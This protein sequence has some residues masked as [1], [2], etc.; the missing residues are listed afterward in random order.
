MYGPCPSIE[1]ERSGL[2][3]HSLPATAAVREACCLPATD[4]CGECVPEEMTVREAATGCRSFI[5]RLQHLEFPTEY[6]DY[7]RATQQQGSPAAPPTAPPTTPVSG[8]HI[9][10]VP[11]PVSERCMSSGPHAVSMIAALPFSTFRLL[12]GLALL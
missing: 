3:L 1:P 9:P 4:C 7:I 12:V 10:S 5:S 11:P 6:Q 2:G 8:P